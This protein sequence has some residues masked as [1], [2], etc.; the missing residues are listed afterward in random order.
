M[1]GRNEKHVK[2]DFE[3]NFE[4]MRDFI[5]IITPTPMGIVVLLILTLSHE[6]LH[7]PER[8]LQHENVPEMK[9]ENY[10]NYCNFHHVVLNS[11]G[12]NIYH[13]SAT[14]RRYTSKIFVF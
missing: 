6:L 1:T 4:L 2:C 5:T 7:D 10:L 8:S 9:S 14:L 11:S 3:I 12:K 13:L